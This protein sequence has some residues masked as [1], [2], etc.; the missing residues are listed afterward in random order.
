MT[1]A[2]VTV[3]VGRIVGP[4]L[5]EGVGSRC[6]IY[7]AGCSLRCHGCFNPH[8]WPVDSGLERSGLDLVSQVRALRGIQ[9]V[10]FLGGEPFD[11]AEQLSW[12][13][14]ALREAG[15]D[16]VTFSGFTHDALIRRSRQEAGVKRLLEATDL[17]ID[18]PFLEA[19]VDE[20]RPW[21]GSDNQRYI[22]LTRRGWKLLPSVVDEDRLEVTVNCD[23]TIH[24][25][26][27]ADQATLIRLHE[28][29]R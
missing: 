3:R 17:L 6:A 7:L 16:V 1:L 26:G 20:S 23:G 24:V 9:G 10:T 5:V 4:T 11:Q 18:G 27:W 8:F 29:I 28:L 13:A 19:R 15:L 25:N 22:P 2:G 14:L 21:L 12:V